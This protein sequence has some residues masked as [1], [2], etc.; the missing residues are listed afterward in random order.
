MRT[1]RAVVAGSV[2]LTT[3]VGEAYV[4]VPEA[5]L[6][7]LV[8]SVLVCTDSVWVRV[9]HAADGGSF[10]VTL[11]TLYDASRFTCSHCGNALL[12]L[13]QYVFAS[14]SVAAGGVR[15]PLTWLLAVAGRPRG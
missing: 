15:A 14:P 4:N 3:L 2:T 12:A 11:P 7:K 9:P 13:S 6:P 5:M 10:S 8:P 1:Y